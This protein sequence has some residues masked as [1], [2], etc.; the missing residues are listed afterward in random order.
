M[1]L[2]CGGAERALYDLVTSIDKNIFDVTVLTIEKGGEWEQ[3]FIEKGIRVIDPFS[4]CKKHKMY[5]KNLYNYLLVRRIENSLYN[6]KNNFIEIATGKKFDI[7][8]SYQLFYGYEFAGF[9]KHGKKIRYFHENVGDNFRYEKIKDDLSRICDK[10]DRIICVSENSKKSLETVVD[11]KNIVSAINPLNYNDVI[12]KSKE[13]MSL[14]I[15]KT[16]I[17]AVGRLCVDKGYDRMIRVFAKLVEMGYQ[18]HLLIIGDGEEKASLK[19]MIIDYSLVGR[20]IL[21]G[22]IDNPYPYIKKAHALVISSVSEGL[23]VVAFEA[24]C[25][26]TPVI[27]SYPSIREAFGDEQCGIVCENNTE[28]DLLSALSSVV[29]D[30]Q[31]YQS[32]IES[33]KKRSRI[34]QSDYYIKEV[35]RIYLQTINKDK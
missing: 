5:I 31:K 10:F 20:V 35:E 24:L 32:I 4:R 28:E 16:Y 33:T 8:V 14:L 11:N 25:L 23:P 17:C 13:K 1:K 2:V 7:V 29:F 6:K 27:S 12:S 26:E 34:I 18:G 21:A 19:K 9:P 15:N 22:Y 30:N 3:R